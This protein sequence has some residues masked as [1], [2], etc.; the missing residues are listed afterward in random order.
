MIIRF[1][2]YKYYV[3][4]PKILQCTYSN[5]MLVH[6]ASILE[7]PN[8][9]QT[10]PVTLLS[11]NVMTNAV[12]LPG[13]P[14]KK[15]NHWRNCNRD[16]QRWGILGHPPCWSGSDFSPR[17]SKSLTFLF[18]YTRHWTLKGFKLSDIPKLWGVCETV[19]RASWHWWLDS[20]NSI[21]IMSYKV[22]YL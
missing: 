22:I 11:P 14:C 21:R 13:F 10:V 12:D 3:I 19:V 5:N 8:N 6:V 7:I 15:S 18:W 17:K 2:Y 4:Q 20:F 16:G 9:V 1:I